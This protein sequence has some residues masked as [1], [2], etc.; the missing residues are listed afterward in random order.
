M[1]LDMIR[2]ATVP[3]AQA[4]TWALLRD[5]PRLSACMP[6]VSDVQVL[7]PDRRY[8][9]L[10]SDR[11]GPF[12]LAV[13]VSIEVRSVEAP[14]RIAAD[15]TGDDKRGQARVRGSLE[16][17]AEATSE[18]STQLQLSMRLEILGR[19]ATLGAVP[20]KRRADE[21][22]SEFLQRLEAELTAHKTGSAAG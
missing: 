7:E 6:K 9:A 11:L 12:G 5:V 13:P 14:Y 20:I 2:L 15:L 1:L 18:A 19:L 17:T 3:V 21:V 8:S 16:A 22:F 4:E 10:V